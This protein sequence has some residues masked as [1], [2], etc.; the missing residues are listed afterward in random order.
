MKRNG[1]LALLICFYFAGYSQTTSFPENWKGNWKGELHW[2][3]AGKQE[4]EK[5]NMELRIHPADTPGH[6]TWHIIY[7]TAQQD[8]RP[9]LLKQTDT[10]GIHW[11]IDEKNGIM[12]DQYWVGDRFTGA[13]TVQQ[14][15]LINSYYMEDN[16]LIVEFTGIGK[17]PFRTTGAGTDESP[18]V[19]S[20]QVRSYQKA[21][22]YR[23]N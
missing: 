12:L 16:K 21:V 18:T 4:P 10:T 6:Y 14:S 15:T 2:Y 9:Y 8:S 19:D 17:K 23:I 13:F 1:L 22:L 7:G 11:V 20:Y 5:V 3:K